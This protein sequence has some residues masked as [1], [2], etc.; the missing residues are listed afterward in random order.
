MNKR[1]SP[2]LF[3]AS[4]AATRPLRLA[5]MLVLVSSIFL[6]PAAAPVRATGTACV[7]SA[8]PS[9]AYTITPCIT[10]PADAATVSGTQTVV[11]TY[12]ATGA[13][14]GVAKLIFYLDGQYLLTDYATPYTFALATDRWVDGVHSLAV[15]A[16]MKD[17][18]TSQRA[19]IT[20]T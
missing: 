10:G 4:L 9:N 16:L 6:G 17:G 11:A 15:E 18:F 5:L 19:S 12:T 13:N 8:P 2:A 7:T 20:L 1:Q 14:P 3:V